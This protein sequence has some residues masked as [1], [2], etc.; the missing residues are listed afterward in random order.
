MYN[1]S[2]DMFREMYKPVSRNIRLLDFGIKMRNSVF[3]HLKEI[4]GSL[5]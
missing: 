3:R 1:T 2:L 4:M 5:L